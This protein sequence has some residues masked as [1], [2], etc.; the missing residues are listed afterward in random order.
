MGQHTEADSP[1][2]VETSGWFRMD[3]ISKVMGLAGALVLLVVFVPLWVDPGLEV[4]G[5]PWLFVSQPIA[6]MAIG[7]AFVITTY[8]TDMKYGGD[9]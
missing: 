8:Y 5:Y 6:G 3:P 9:E 2:S 7:I 1:Q 4:G